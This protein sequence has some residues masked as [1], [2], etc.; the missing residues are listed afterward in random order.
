LNAST[1]KV[2]PAWVE[3]MGITI[4]AGRGLAESDG[5]AH[6]P[7]PVV[8]NQSFV[9]HFFPGAN[10][11]GR[12]FGIGRDQV[13]TAAYEIVGV[14]SDSRYRSFREPFQPTLFSCFCGTRTTD[15]VFQLEVRS[16][17]PPE[18]VIAPV[19]AVMRKI[20]PRL[21]FREIRTMRR[22]VDDS[23]WA[24]RT[25]AAVG[26]G[27]SLLAAVVACVG[28]YGLLFFTLAHGAARSAFDGVGR[29]ARRH[30]PCHVAARA[31]HPARRRGPGNRGLRARRAPDGEC[32]LRGRSRQLD[33]QRRGCCRD[34]VGRTRGSGATCLA[35][36]AR[37]PLA[38]PARRLSLI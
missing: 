21:P 36:V 38:N 32:A 14:A 13:V 16:A 37:G 33:Y 20:D 24:E 2:S 22:D 18:N 30:R 1:N 15:A 7:E 25:L 12:Q 4:L 6:Q 26:S 8:V 29:A 23:L 11:L 28:L 34:A 19:E 5:A 10:P 31:R 35:C 27:L 17:G 9:R 3:A